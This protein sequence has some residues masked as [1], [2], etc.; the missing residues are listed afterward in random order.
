MNKILLTAL[1]IIVV[2]LLCSTAFAQ[3]FPH[4]KKI[5][6]IE[7]N[8]KKA[9]EKQI[10][11]EKEAEQI[12]KL[13]EEN[14]KKWK[15]FTE[16]RKSFRNKFQS[17]AT[18]GKSLQ[19]LNLMSK[20]RR[21]FGKAEIYYRVSNW[22]KVSKELNLV[23]KDKQSREFQDGRG[24]E[25]YIYTKLADIYEGEE[26]NSKIE[27]K[28]K[29]FIETATK[30]TILTEEKREVNDHHDSRIERL[31]R[32]RGFVNDY[33][34]KVKRCEELLA[35]IKRDTTDPRTI[36]TLIQ[37][38]RYTLLL[39]MRQMEWVEVLK[40]EFPD[41]PY[42]ILGW[43]RAY[44]GEQLGKIGK[45]EEGTKLLNELRSDF[46]TN[47]KKLER[48][49]RALQKKMKDEGL[50]KSDLTPTERAIVESDVKKMME[51]YRDFVK[52]YIGKFRDS[53][54]Q[55]KKWMRGGR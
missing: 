7:K 23:L 33:M 24:F 9:E 44:Y 17:S 43:D 27:K 47:R 10:A 49:K 45:V 50:R 55:I 3:F 34:D 40:K 20:Y 4:K 37:H 14:E 31:S 46:E 35:Q 6:D 19:V 52:H 26:F 11:K 16:I 21:Y 39:P 25:L 41:S 29:K 8:V 12:A 36:W 53:M 42:V 30:R 38:Y 15:K 51:K 54:K 1:T 28:L 5:D 13:K 18:S 48:K 22:S 32:L 2:M